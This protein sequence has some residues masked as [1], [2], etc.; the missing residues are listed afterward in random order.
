MPN[1]PSYAQKDIAWYRSHYAL[2]QS[3]SENGWSGSLIRFAQMTQP[4]RTCLVGDAFL[5]NQWNASRWH[6]AAHSM[7][8]NQVDPSPDPRQLPPAPSSTRKDG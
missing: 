8:G 6:I 1:G 2:N 5:R 4:S 7:V 3:I